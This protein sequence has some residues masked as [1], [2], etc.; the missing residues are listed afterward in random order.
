M[1]VCI[2]ALCRDLSGHPSAAAVVASDR[3]VT[4]GGITEFEHEIPKIVPLADR[5]LELAAGDG[6]RA[7]RL[8][9]DVAAA[10][11]SG[12]VM[13]GD[14]AQLLAVRYADHRRQQVESDLFIPRGITIAQ[15][16]GGLQSQLLGQLV[17]MIDS[18]VMNFNFGVSSLIAGVDDAG[19]H[20][21]S[22]HNPGAS[23]NDFQSIGFDA[24]GSG[25]L[26]ALQSLIGFGQ[27]GVD[28]LHETV[29]SV[30]VS[31]RRAE[32]APGVGRDTDM[33]VI[34]AEGVTYF[35]RALLEQLD[36]LYV[37]LHRPMT[38]ELKGRLARLEIIRAVEPRA[39]S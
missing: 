8:A 1:T 24:I 26:H 34:T 23:V 3:M 14:V 36:A 28:P 27:A 31:K 37:E 2:G 30:Y 13:V 7:G 21:Y 10:V 9:R 18:Q 4:H 39:A 5:I 25:G 22:V 35:D 19:A 33:A 6:L 32:S 15:F 16:Y 38:E 11:P 29:F 17:G 12:P 20:L